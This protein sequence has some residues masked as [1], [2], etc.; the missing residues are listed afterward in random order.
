MKRLLAAAVVVAALAAAAPASAEPQRYDSGRG[1]QDDRGYRDDRGYTDDRGYRPSAG[2][3][4]RGGPQRGVN[5]FS[6]DDLH[7]LQAR[8]DWGVR[9]GALNRYEARRLQYQLSEL[10]GRARYYWRT[11]GVSWRERQ[12]L[13]QRY[14]YLRAEVRRQ[15]RDDDYG[16]GGGYR[17]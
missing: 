6:P 17:R 8:I 5:R 3:D 2:Y 4:H 7:R 14:D 11:D 13:E 10:R 16:R 9:S 15:I 12:D 1:Y